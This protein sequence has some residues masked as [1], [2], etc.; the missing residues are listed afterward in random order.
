MN[1]F[2]KD[3]N[4]QFTEEFEWPKINLKMLNL[5]NYKRNEN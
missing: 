3:M 2:A 5:S 4:S 1:K